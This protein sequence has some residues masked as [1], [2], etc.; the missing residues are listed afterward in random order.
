[1]KT[2]I[3]QY[4]DLTRWDI[5]SFLYILESNFPIEELGL[6][7]YEHSEKENIFEQ[8]EKEFPI[9][10]VTNKVGVYLNEN[11]KGAEINQPYKKVKAG[12][13][14]YNPYR[15]NVGSIGIVRDEFDGFYISPAYVVFGTKETLLNEYLYLVLS[16]SWFNPFLRSATSGSV[17]QNLTYDLL[18][19]LKVPVPDIKTQQK[20][21]ANFHKVKIEAKKLRDKANKIEK[22][23]NELLMRELGMERKEYL[24]EKS[25]FVVNYKELERWSVDYCNYAS[26][27]LLDIRSKYDVLP[28]KRVI[29]R[30]QYGTSEK[31]SK[32]KNG[33][34]ILRMNNIVNGQIDTKNIKY[35][36]LSP[37]V[38]N[39]LR[40]NSGDI[41]FNRTNSKELVGKTAVFEL[42]REWVFA[43]YL[44]RIELENDKIDSHFF[45]C[46]FN[47]PI[48]RNQIN[49]IS[50]R[51]IG[52]ANIN[53]EEVSNLLIPIP[54]L[55]VQKTIVSKI[56]KKRAEIQ[57]LHAQSVNI[58]ESAKN[59][60][61]VTVVKT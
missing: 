15:V 18:R 42:D 23:V 35:I 17:R 28:A 25:V 29:K 16:S 45:N 37:G 8:K 53:T 20:I 31:A 7:I 50:R 41:V 9:L 47:S 21:V 34:P 60:L 1:M 58:L 38:A 30:F 10:G 57:E 44:V 48:I 36:N 12:E 2:V 13:L 56:E 27:G 55:K 11:K 61:R 26:Q 19:N 5:K 24:K 49:A 22:Q 54:P 14:T 51:I 40:L 6:H 32:T 46:V 3:A 4:K 52:Q 43:S 59:D 39:T 33:L